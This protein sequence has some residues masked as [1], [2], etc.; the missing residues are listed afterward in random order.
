MRSF[1]FNSKGFYRK[2]SGDLLCHAQVYVFAEEFD[3]KPLKELSLRKLHEKLGSKTF[4]IGDTVDLL[5]YVYEN[6]VDLVS[7]EEKLRALVVHY[8]ACFVEELIPNKDFQSLLADKGELGR[9]LMVKMASR[10][11]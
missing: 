2:P 9:D 4:R 7:F 6:T 10:L 11:E 8:A 1:I 3:I 5:K